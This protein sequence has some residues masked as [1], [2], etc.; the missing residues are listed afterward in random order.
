ME[1]AHPFD[2]NRGRD[3]YFLPNQ[4]TATVRVLGLGLIVEGVL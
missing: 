1:P 4:M 2:K 3:Y